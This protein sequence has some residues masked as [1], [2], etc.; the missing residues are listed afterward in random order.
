LQINSHFLIYSSCLLPPKWRTQDWAGVKLLA[1][2]MGSKWQ[3]WLMD[4]SR[5]YG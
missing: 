5:A 4:V 1:T 3:W 2:F